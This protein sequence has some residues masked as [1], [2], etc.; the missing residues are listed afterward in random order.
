MASFESYSPETAQEVFSFEK[1]LHEAGVQFDDDNGPDER[2]DNCGYDAESDKIVVPQPPRLVDRREE[3]LVIDDPEPTFNRKRRDRLVRDKV[4]KP[5][6][7][8][9][10]DRRPKRSRRRDDVRKGPSESR[11]RNTRPNRPQTPPG[12][13]PNYGRRP[14][15]RTSQPKRQSNQRYKTPFV[16][17]LEYMNRYG[18]KEDRRETIHFSSGMN[19]QEQK[20]F[21]RYFLGRGVTDVGIKHHG[22]ARKHPHPH[23]A[24]L[25]KLAI[26]RSVNK[27][28]EAAKT[29][30]IRVL[31]VG[32]GFTRRLYHMITR[33][34]TVSGLLPILIHD[35][36]D[37]VV[38]GVISP[39]NVLKFQEHITEAMLEDST[40]HLTDPP[41][42]IRYQFFKCSLQQFVAGDSFGGYTGQDYDYILFNHSLYYF[43]P[44]DIIALANRSPTS[45]MYAVLHFFDKPKGSFTFGHEKESFTEARWSTIDGQISMTTNGNFNSYQH[46]SPT[47]VMNGGAIVGDR[48]I[49]CD[50]QPICEGL[51]TYYTSLTVIAVEPGQRLA[52]MIEP[53]P[54][55]VKIPNVSVGLPKKCYDNIMRIVL[56]KADLR[57]GPQRSSVRRIVATQVKKNKE[58]SGFGP[59]VDRIAEIV[60]EDFAASRRKHAWWYLTRGCCLEPFLGDSTGFLA[61]TL[62]ALTQCLSIGRQ[63]KILILLT[64]LVLFSQ[65][66][67]VVYAIVGALFFMTSK[68]SFLR[69]LAFLP[70]LIIVIVAISV[71]VSTKTVVEIEELWDEIAEGRS[72]NGI[73]Y[74]VTYTG[75]NLHAIESKYDKHHDMCPSTQMKIYDQPSPKIAEEVKG[76]SC[77]GPLFVEAMP[78][79]FGP[80]QN[81]VTISARTRACVQPPNIIDD[82]QC[83]CT[84]CD[85]CLAW[86][87]FSEVQ[88]DR[89]HA[90]VIEPMDFDDWNRRFPKGKRTTN[91]KAYDKVMSEGASQQDFYYEGFV[92]REP[93]VPGFTEN[94][95]DELR[96]RMISAVSKVWKVLTG[97]WMATFAIWVK[98]T[99]H[100]FS[101]IWYVSGATA[102]DISEWATRVMNGMKNPKFFWLDFSKYDATQKS[103]AMLAEIF[104]FE[105]FGAAD[106]IPYWEEIKKAKLLKKVYTQFLQYF[107]SGTRGSGENETSVGNSMLNITIFFLSVGRYSAIVDKPVDLV[108]QHIYCAIMGDDFISI[109]DEDYVD[110]NTFSVVYNQT[111]SD[112]GMTIISGMSHNPIYADFLRMMFYPTSTGVQVGRFPGRNICKSGVI[113]HKHNYDDRGR[114]A[115]LFSNLN[116]ALPTSHHVPFLR[117]Y[118]KETM[119]YLLDNYPDLSLPKNYQRYQRTTDRGSIVE[120]DETTWNAFEQRFGLNEADEERFGLYYADALRQHGL[121][122]LLSWPELLVL[123]DL[124]S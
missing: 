115:I 39:Y 106:S 38:N 121:Y 70:V 97:P 79:S 27:I 12:P 24:F 67:Y 52:K 50:S 19:L 8:Q 91:Q 15:Q 98:N 35:V 32:S 55:D 3:E 105:R 36:D 60:V 20:S 110:V 45:K 124:E 96:P 84:K 90:E 61:V 74:N 63:Y 87:E 46:P 28:L 16:D 107:V 6:R 83:N 66:P 9:N 122:S 34:S 104:L 44:A 43:N 80:T 21:N 58:L 94:G 117:V 37:V 71:C 31:N 18:H 113:V 51:G 23:L 95:T 114:A 108:L 29:K 17:S 30:S 119:K 48:A 109:I 4:S 5:R 118:V 40:T 53:K 10:R 69:A 56:Q 22:A 86:K 65:F 73:P 100:K 120:A 42:S 41:R 76:L 92:K 57:K 102:E 64:M 1:T 88:N 85:Y 81:N 54:T 77:I 59:H 99:Y 78:Y 33:A 82:G 75:R 14:P 72:S 26:C 93:N 111:V 89:I 116:S 25:R 49:I 7:K 62:Q 11:H 101:N 47:W 13:P 112:L 68:V 2:W 103:K 123:V